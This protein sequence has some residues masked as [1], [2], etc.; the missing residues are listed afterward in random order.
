MD[1][2]KICIIYDSKFKKN[3]FTE[4]ISDGLSLNTVTLKLNIIE[5]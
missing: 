3:Y 1:L 2:T 4:G 5:I